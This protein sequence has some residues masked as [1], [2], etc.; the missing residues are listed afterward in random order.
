MENTV[1][2]SE[3]VDLLSITYWD[4]GKLF[5]FLSAQYQQDFFVRFFNKR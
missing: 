3:P 1:I 2:I 5:D 4:A